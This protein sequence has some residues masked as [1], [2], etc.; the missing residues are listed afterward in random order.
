MKYFLLIIISIFSS[1][2]VYCS[3]KIPNLIKEP[4]S[5]T[6]ENCNQVGCDRFCKKPSDP[7]YDYKCTAY[8]IPTIINQSQTCISY[9]I[10]CLI[11]QIPSSHI[12][13]DSE[14]CTNLKPENSATLNK[15]NFGVFSI[16]ILIL[17]DIQ[18]F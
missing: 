5:L 15:A 1:S 12:G 17:K 3:E 8:C 18:I 6:L 16:F 9:N 13:V 14:S 2:S 10:S 11:N 7:N 4:S